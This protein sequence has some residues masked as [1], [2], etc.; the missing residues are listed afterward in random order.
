MACHD[1]E[2]RTWTEFIVCSRIVE[3]SYIVA[4]PDME[5]VVLNVDEDMDEV[6]MGMHP[7]DRPIL[8]VID[9]GGEFYCLEDGP[10]GGPLPVR[11]LAD[12][13]DRGEQLALSIRR[14]EEPQHF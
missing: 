8:A 10:A 6:A 12:L 5:L 7:H 4:D 9:A 1:A 13:I 3:S 14:V 2:T 11:T